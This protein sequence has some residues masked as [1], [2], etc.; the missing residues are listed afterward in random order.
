MESQGGKN[1]PSMH[2][3]LEFFLPGCV[4]MGLKNR[5]ILNG[6]DGKQW[7]PY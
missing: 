4:S 7:D 2:I 6:L 3:R 1:W 5:L